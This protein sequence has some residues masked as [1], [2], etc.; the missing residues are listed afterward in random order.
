MWTVCVVGGEAFPPLS[1]SIFSSLVALF[2]RSVSRRLSGTWRRR[3]LQEEDPTWRQ[4]TGSLRASCCSALCGWVSAA[5]QRW[6]HNTGCHYLRKICIM[7]TNNVCYTTRKFCISV[8]N[9][10]KLPSDVFGRAEA[11][12]KLLIQFRFSDDLDL[13]CV[14]MSGGCVVL[15][16]YHHIWT[17]M[18]VL[19]L[20][21]WVS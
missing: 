6:V 1:I 7:Q 17:N 15:P 11:C 14:C 8:V 10:V 19:H 20:V 12:V 16:L 18:K 9:C 4:E 5:Q 13:F 3:R 2:W 21:A